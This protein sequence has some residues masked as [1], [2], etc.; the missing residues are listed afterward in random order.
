M[1]APTSKFKKKTKKDDFLL[2]RPVTRLEK[3][4]PYDEKRS[5]SKIK[6]LGQYKIPKAL[7]SKLRLAVDDAVEAIRRQ[8]KFPF[9][10]QSY[11]QAMSTLLHAEE[12]ARF[13][14][15]REY[16]IH[17]A[18][19]EQTKGKRY[20]L[21]VPGLAEARPS[22]IRTD[23]I[24]I[25][26]SKDTTNAQAFQGWVTE[27]HEKRVLIEFPPA[28]NKVY[29]ENQR[30]DV[31][32]SFNRQPFRR[33]HAALNNPTSTRFAF[34]DTKTLT[35]SDDQFAKVREFADKMECYVNGL[36]SNAEQKLAAYII[37]NRLHGDTPFV[38]YGPP[39]TGK[40]NTLV[41]A[42][43]QIRRKADFN[44][45]RYHILVC[46]PSNPAAD[47]IL[48]RL[49][50]AGINEDE[51]IRVNSPS[52]SKFTMPMKSGYERYCFYDD[53]K[54]F[55]Y[56]T[57]DEIDRASIVIMTNIAA[58]VLSFFGECRE[59]THIILDEAAQCFEPETLVP[60]QMAKPKTSVVLAGDHHQLGPMVRSPVAHALGLGICMLERLVNLPPNKT[61]YPWGQEPSKSSNLCGVKLLKNYRSH[62]EL[63]SLSSRLFYKNELLY[64]APRFV[65]EQFLQ[66]PGL[67][68]EGYPLK[69]VGVE[70]VDE[71]EGNSPSWF[72]VFE[73]EAVVREIKSL[74]DYSPLL[75]G[76]YFTVSGK[77]IGVIV[78]YRKQVEKIMK[79]L[80]HENV[81]DRDRIKVDT[82]ERFQG[83]ERPVMIVSTV[84]SQAQFLEQDKK[85]NLGFVSNPKRFNVSITRA[86][87]LLIIVGNP[88]VLIHD[89]YWKMQI[90]EIA[91]RGGATGASVPMHDIKEE[92]CVDELVRLVDKLEV[93]QP[94]EAEAYGTM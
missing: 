5:Y 37:A 24:T 41:E 51:M 28:F 4:V 27:V 34:P 66:W 15:I 39:G 20:F 32:F 6:A 47:L 38:L 7:A 93:Q 83:L 88:N 43:L 58:G 80:T 53:E 21:A 72:N 79:L 91:T 3:A 18:R 62:P 85:F 29:H 52:R 63:M 71:R 11:I 87:A 44:K 36:N 90:R 94:I 25:S 35:I 22:V 14:D 33:M 31:R 45:E 67:P 56:P 2:G 54:H 16:D 50:I 61:P 23:S 68:Q 48:T 76:H 65:V 1:L 73:A 12:D 89:E 81:R 64:E 84:R 8:V 70:G 17:G 40:T 9:T 10:T 13:I 42:I 49:S 19:L 75:D 57:S 86:R 30:Y 59:F 77:D 74:L 26:P 92:D 46:T 82:V 55:I 69:F 60:L 78:P